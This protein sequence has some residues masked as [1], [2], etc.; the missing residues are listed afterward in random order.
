[1]HIKLDL[2]LSVFVISSKLIDEGQ[3]IDAPKCMLAG[4]P[5]NKFHNYGFG[6]LYLIALYGYYY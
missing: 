6:W 1:M 5:Y 3:S 2:Q 4:K